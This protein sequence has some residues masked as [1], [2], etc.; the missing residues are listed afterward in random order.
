MKNQVT[1][2]SPGQSLPPP[3]LDLSIID[4]AKLVKRFNLFSQQEEVEHDP[5]KRSNEDLMRLSSQLWA[6]KPEEVTY[7]D[8]VLS[9]ALI[10]LAGLVCELVTN[11]LNNSHVENQEAFDEVFSKKSRNGKGLLTVS[12]HT[13]I[14]EDP[15]L[16]AAFYRRKYLDGWKILFG[17][18]DQMQNFKR[19]LAAKEN[20]FWHKNPILRKFFRWFCGRT[21]TAPIIRHGGLDQIVLKELEKRLREGDWIHLFG[22]GTRTD[23]YGKLNEFRP[24]P[25]KMIS[26]A[27]NTV[28]LPW[29]HDG[30]E[31]VMPSGCSKGVRAA[32][33]KEI[34]DKFV[35][36]GKRTQIVFGKPMD[37]SKMAKETPKTTDGYMKIANIIRVEVEKCLK[38]AIEL[39]RMAGQA[40]II[41]T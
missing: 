19:T 24:G 30:F 13:N 21:K 33:P 38:R 3:L 34:C 32:M 8:K 27:P 40:S 20:F 37:L 25:G 4:P 7:Y 14:I 11:V 6:K 31:Q 10:M 23:E 18:D 41:A 12:N 28:V 2:R 1:D 26:E 9:S 22:E 35:Q 15:I 16:F 29:A 39:N 5:T 17:N 36:T